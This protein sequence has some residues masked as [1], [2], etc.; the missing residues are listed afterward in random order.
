VL[1]ANVVCLPS[2][3]SKTTIIDSEIGDDI[4]LDCL[5][6]RKKWTLPSILQWRRSKNNYSIPIASQFDDYPVHI[7]D[8]YLNK[9]SFFSN[10]SLNIENIQ[11]NDNDTFECRLILLDRG[12]LDIKENYFLTLRV[13]GMFHERSISRKRTKPLFFF[14][15][16][17]NNRVLS[18]DLIHYK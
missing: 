16:F 4:T 7:D 9:Y 1:I 12:L 8:L 15:S 17:K 18:I 2:L 11:L 6:D 10:G 14:V 5:I 3:L 13:N